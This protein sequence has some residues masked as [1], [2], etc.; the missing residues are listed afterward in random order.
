MASSL[1]RTLL[2]LIGGLKDSMGWAALLA[3]AV[4]AFLIGLALFGRPQLRDSAREILRIIFRAPDPSWSPLAPS[5]GEQRRGE[6]RNRD[7]DGH[8][9]VDVDRYIA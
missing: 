2:D 1:G 3:A 9:P 5:V 7:S 4:V 6:I 8:D